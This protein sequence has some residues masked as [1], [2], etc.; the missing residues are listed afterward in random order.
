MWE[1]I[2]TFFFDQAGAEHSGDEGHH[3]R[4]EL[5]MAAAGLLVTAS[6]SDGKQSDSER[7]A[8]AR[9][10]TARFELPEDEA[11]SLLAVAD[12]KAE[13]ALDLYQ[14][15][16]VLTDNFPPEERVR[17]IEMLWKVVYADGV[18]DDFE[19]HLIRRC[20]GLLF[21]SDKDSGLA[22]QRV[23]AKLAIDQD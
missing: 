15:T 10:L 21:V 12:Q 3:S 1:R 18:I 23:R 13:E 19:A 14:F 6:I 2:K 5:H 17:V 8:I 16:R 7:E 9:I 22:K 4:D 20:A 11:H